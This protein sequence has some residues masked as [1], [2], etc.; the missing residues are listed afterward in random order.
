VAA[1]GA[2][3]LDTAWTLHHLATG[4]YYWSVQSIDN[5]YAGS[6][7]ATEGTFTVG[8][9]VLLAFSPDSIAFGTV[10]L[11]GS[12][13]D[14]IKVK[15]TGALLAKVFKKSVSDTSF[16]VTPD[17]VT[18]A[19]GDSGKFFVKFKPARAATF[20]ATLALSDNVTIHDTVRLSGIGINPGVAAVTPKSIA[21]DSV[22]VFL[23]KKDSLKV[24]NTGGTPLQVVA[25]RA[26]ADTASFTV[27]PDTMT[28]NAGDSTK[29]F[30][31]FAPMAVRA[32]AARILFQSAG[33]TDTVTL[34]GTGKVMTLAALR[35]A[36][37]GSVGSFQGV[38][39]RAK[40]SY[41]YLQDS[42]GGMVVY[43]PTGA[44]HDT[45]RSGFI[46]SGDR[47]LI[48]GKTSVFNNLMEIA[49][50]DLSGWLRVAR[51]G[52]VTPATVTLTQLKTGGEKYESMLVRV[53]QLQLVG[54]ADTLF[55]AAKTYNVKDLG[56][57]SKAVALR[58]PN[59]G[60]SDEDSTVINKPTAT[61]SW[62]LTF[63][64]V[65]G[66]FSSS[67]S[68]KGY[69]L[70]AVSAGDIHFDSLV[71]GV[72][73]GPLAG[74]GAVP[75]VYNLSQNYPN[76]FNPSTTIEFALPKASSVELK[77]YTTLGQ[78]VATLVQETMSAGRHTVSFNAGRLASG[79]YFYR[80]SAGDFNSVRKMMLVK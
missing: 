21:F 39:S 72:P 50:T 14:S 31:T 28:V 15:N 18:I 23:T 71:T 78:E 56:D 19:A 58:I 17:S 9:P 30:V 76:P 49:T 68:S 46:A 6:A 45:L 63:T 4:V 53:V 59:A 64:G 75:T 2:Q 66:Q 73:E 3:N 33:K 38:V 43:Q 77:V 51:R 79:L 69:Q 67:D 47:L 10:I 44:F 29:F 48:S 40:G 60:D 54:N 24:K 61:K 36:P 57:T 35:K 11:P 32:H 74:E 65:L 26:G 70:M 25:K 12:K 22:L 16:I 37:V 42:T 55:K 13:T 7:F 52:S 27:K 41:T 62:R 1:P 80:I 5:G 20:H 8:N 34:T